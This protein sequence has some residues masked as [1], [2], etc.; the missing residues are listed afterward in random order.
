M[1]EVS[2][3]S[4]TYNRLSMLKRMVYS[5][6]S[7]VGDA[8][9][10]III[11]DGGSTDGSLEWLRAQSDVKLIEHGE[12]LGAIKA[13]NDGAA[14]ARGEYVVFA[15]DDLTFVGDSIRRALSFMYTHSDVGIGLFHT[16][17][18]GHR[19]HIAQ[20]PAHHPDGQMVNAPYNGVIITSRWFGNRLGWWTLDGARTYGGDCAFCA[21][22]IESGWSVIGIEGAKVN[23][24]DVTDTLKQI[25]TVPTNDNHPDTAAYLRVFPRGPQLGNTRQF[26]APAQAAH[27][28][29]A[30]IYEQ[31]H[32]V[33]HE[34][35]RG[36]RRA[37]QRIG[38][39]REID[40]IDAGPDAILRTAAEFQ[41]NIVLTQLHYADPFTPA[42][43]NKLRAL[44]PNAKL[45]NWNGDVYNRSD[46]ADY[47]R[48]L[49]NFDLHTVVNAS[50]IDA[51]VA[52]GVR[53]AYWQVGYEPD[54]VGHEPDI[55]TPAHDVIFMGNGY[56]EERHRFGAIIRA[57]PA[58]TAIYGDYWPEG[59][60]HSTTLYD[61]RR[62]C[63]LYRNAKIAL[64]DSDWSKEGG[65]GFVSNRP[66]QAMAAGNCLMLQQW[67][68]GCEEMLHLIDGK[69]LVLW[70][71]YDDL[72][73]KVAYYLAHEKERNQIA[74]AGQLEALKR[75]SFEARIQELRSLLEYRSPVPPGVRPGLVDV[76]YA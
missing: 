17:R 32:K 53:T 6:R 7:S 55:A 37:L 60:A 15:N 2:I 70:S 10:E 11:V 50:A 52:K 46:D 47:V 14:L 19:W 73:E 5:V 44:L 29:Y 38:I 69:H 8:S 18:S 71:D 40:Y 35:K 25:N 48:L 16:N 64:G 58:E 62:G 30:P 42:H 34:Q 41:P 3:I 51:Y 65:K 39:V 66:F 9:Y 24:P 27:I 59:W 33:Q 54:G 28:L 36:L 21:R 49:R 57:L 1:L 23:E 4:G 43:A 74:R 67:F 22:A 45:I 61:F 68:D 20:M 72:R 76:T 63:Q 12:L 31:R 75:H 56:R 26:E 13:Y